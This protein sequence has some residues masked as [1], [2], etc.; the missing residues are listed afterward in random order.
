M[1][2]TVNFFMYT[3]TYTKLKRRESIAAVSSSYI[4]IYCFIH[5]QK[6]RYYKTVPIG[7]WKLKDPKFICVA[8]TLNIEII[9]WLTQFLLEYPLLAVVWVQFGIY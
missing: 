4:S 3:S 7:N 9:A 8:L 1:T 5:L 6:L 2:E